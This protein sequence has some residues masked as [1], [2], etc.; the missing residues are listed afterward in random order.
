MTQP[1]AD[2]DRVKA[3]LRGILAATNGAASITHCHDALKQQGI[4][5]T[6][7]M[8][9]RL[10]RELKGEGVTNLAEEAAKRA[11]KGLAS[12]AKTG[13]LPPRRMTKDDAERVVSTLDAIDIAVVDLTALVTGAAARVQ[14]KSA[15]QLAQVSQSIALLASTV[16]EIRK[17]QHEMQQAIDASEGAPRMHRPGGTPPL[18]VLA[19]A[20]R[21][22]QNG[23]GAA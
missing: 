13:E 2:P 17:T 14:I 3:A 15:A 7:T 19:E 10:L 5:A 1:H 18:T 6:R 9:A 12:I 4:N 21:R 20:Y 22:H 23:D 11:V 16:A 8:V